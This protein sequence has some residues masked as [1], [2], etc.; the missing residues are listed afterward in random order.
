MYDQGHNR[1][2]VLAS[3]LEAALQAVI[4]CDGMFCQLRSVARAIALEYPEFMVWSPELRGAYAVADIWDH[5]WKR[6]AEVKVEASK[7]MITAPM[8]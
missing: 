8:W 3:E 4:D 2:P 1:L 6:L 7:K 5:S